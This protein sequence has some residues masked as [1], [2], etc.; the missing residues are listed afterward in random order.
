MHRSCHCSQKPMKPM[1]TMVR[2]DRDRNWNS[3]MHMRDVRNVKDE[4]DVKDVSVCKDNQWVRE[5]P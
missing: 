2:R 4:K 3:D 5:L 1:K